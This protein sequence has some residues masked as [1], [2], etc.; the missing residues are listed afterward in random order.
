MRK[1]DLIRE[2]AHQAQMPESR[3]TPIVNSVFQTIQNALAKG[4]EVAIS[5]FGT[6]RVVERPARVGRNP[7]KPDE[8]IRIGPRKSPVFRAGAS[9]PRAVGDTS[10]E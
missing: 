8:M 7:Q 2:V 10:E 1:Q 3:V 6:F 4:D 9:L 5:G